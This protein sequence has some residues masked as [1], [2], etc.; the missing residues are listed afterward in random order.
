[1]P[2]APTS[3]LP[4]HHDFLAALVGSVVATLRHESPYCVAAAAALLNRVGT[5]V[6]CRAWFEISGAIPALVRVVGRFIPPADREK[7]RG[8]FRRYAFKY[9]FHC[10]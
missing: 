9:D 5:S 7:E 8:L 10:L 6:V 1:M 3:W 4:W 2:A